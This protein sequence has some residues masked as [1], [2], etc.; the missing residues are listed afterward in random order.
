LPLPQI[1]WNTPPWTKPQSSIG[2]A[3]EFGSVMS[4]EMPAESGC[5]KST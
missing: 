4:R 2:S 5:N 1:M 3:H